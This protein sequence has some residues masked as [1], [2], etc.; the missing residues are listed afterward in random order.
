MAM[1]RAPICWKRPAPG[2]A[3]FL[4]VAIDDVGDSLALVDAVRREF[5]QLEIL[6]RARNVSHYYDLLDR[7]VT[8]IERETFEASLQ[9]GGRLLQQLGFSASRAQQVVHKFRTHNLKTLMAVYPHYKDQA[10]MVSM[11]Q[12]GREELEEMFARDAEELKN[13]RS[14]TEG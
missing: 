1:P 9:L 3:K 12:Q 8:I 6:A 7:G 13:A 14:G 5:P 4:V 2:H 11:L 10:Q